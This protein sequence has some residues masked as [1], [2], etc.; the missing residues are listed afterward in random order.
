MKTLITG[1]CEGELYPEIYFQFDLKR[2][3][4]LYSY[5]LKIPKK[6]KI[7]CKD[8]EEAEKELDKLNN[9]SQI[10]IIGSCK[11]LCVA[12]AISDALKRRMNVFSPEKY[13]FDYEPVILED[14]VQLYFGLDKKSK[15]I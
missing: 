1:M 6:N 11:G 7:I 9:E 14:V 4:E 15:E 12:G 10:E 2:V 13:L 5:L 3:G 8:D